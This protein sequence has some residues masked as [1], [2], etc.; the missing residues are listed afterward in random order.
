MALSTSATAS[1]S[2]SSSLSAPTRLPS[3][4]SSTA[5]RLLSGGVEVEVGSELTLP[6]LTDDE[7]NAMLDELIS[8]T[9]L[10]EAVMVEGPAVQRLHEEEQGGTEEKN[11]QHD[12]T[13]AAA[14]GGDNRDAREQR[15]VGKRAAAAVRDG[16]GP[17]EVEG[18]D[19]ADIN[20]ATQCTLT[21]SAT[22]GR[23]FDRSTNQSGSPQ[24]RQLSPPIAALCTALSGLRRSTH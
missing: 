1:S 21:V 9:A 23:V 16:A 3:L 14:D 17:G 19:D 2:S 4:L 18:A 8:S 12:S 13:S 5:S 7:Y 6:Q 22:S 15:M 24:L 20:M 11:G 10:A